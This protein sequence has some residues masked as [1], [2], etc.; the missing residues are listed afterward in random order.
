VRLIELYTSGGCSSC[1]LAERWFSDLL[2]APHLWSLLVPIA[3][4]VSYL[5]YLGWLDSFAL[6][7]YA[8]KKKGLR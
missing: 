3:F 5:D 1:P 6:E 2:N 8:Q 4:H 7:E